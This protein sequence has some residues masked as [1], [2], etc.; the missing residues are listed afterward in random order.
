[1]VLQKPA[2]LGPSY[3][4]P[5]KLKVLLSFLGSGDRTKALEDKVQALGRMV[6]VLATLLKNSGRLSEEEHRVVFAAATGINA[7]GA[8][9]DFLDYASKVSKAAEPK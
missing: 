5:E 4:D 8:P 1:M 9:P 3:P 6:I 2:T 7:P